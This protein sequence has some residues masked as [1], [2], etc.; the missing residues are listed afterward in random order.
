MDRGAPHSLIAAALAEGSER[1][2]MV[3]M[4]RDHTPRPY[5]ANDLSL[6]QD[7]TERATMALTRTGLYVQSQQ[8][9][10]RALAIA[11][12]SRAF[13]A[14]EHDPRAILDL[15]A[16]VVVA[17][18]GELAVANLIS[19]DG[20]HVQPVAFHAEREVTEE[21]QALFATRTPLASTLTERIVATGQ[22]LRL[23]SLEF[24][25]LAAGAGARRGSRGRD[26]IRR[27]VA[28]GSAAELQPDVA[29]LDIG[30]PVMDG[31]DLARRLKAAL[32][33][34]PRLVAITG[35]GQ[36]HDHQR[37]QEAGFDA[38]L[39]KPVQAAQVLAVVDDS[40]R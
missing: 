25:K 27:P 5:T 33:S 21:V 17:E 12:A 7:L 23:S 20:A 3:M 28:L 29:L 35:Y 40:S 26:R 6:L 39:V 13:T 18:V 34:S 30:L 10:R 32:P 37:S 4:I 36:E 8:E 14:A 19:D 24:E 11:N 2:G 9:R 38:H 31:Y 22:P 1:I 16:R 15:L